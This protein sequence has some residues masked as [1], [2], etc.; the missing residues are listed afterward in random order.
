MGMLDQALLQQEKKGQ[1]ETNA[2]LD[3]LLV[4]QQRT[5]ELLSQLIGLLS[6]RGGMPM[7]TP[8]T[9]TTWGR[10]ES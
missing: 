5:N 9:T 8:P 3:A 10:R 7:P 4:E 6:A 2:R 1:G